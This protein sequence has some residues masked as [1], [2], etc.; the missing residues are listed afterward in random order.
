MIILLSILIFL[1]IV[2]VV[3]IM[4]LAK[5]FNALNRR[6]EALHTAL[7][8]Q[9]KTLDD[10]LKPLY[11]RVDKIDDR[12]PIIIGWCETLRKNQ[13]I[14]QGDLEK[15]FYGTKKDIRKVEK[16]QERAAATE[17]QKPV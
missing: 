9:L 2:G 6:F 10:Q 5:M 1:Y 8:K 4:A 17:A 14:L 15:V 12:M 13:D 16:Q 7:N 11:E 3:V